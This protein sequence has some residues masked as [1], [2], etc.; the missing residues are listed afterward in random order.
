MVEDDVRNTTF[1]VVLVYD[2]CMSRTTINIDVEACAAVMRRYYMK[3][4]REAV[5]FALRALAC[6]PKPDTKPRNTDELRK[7]RWLGWDFDLDELR[8]PS[9]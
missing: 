8:D 2:I 4:K 5:N 7:L 9:K 6:K 3:T 1:S